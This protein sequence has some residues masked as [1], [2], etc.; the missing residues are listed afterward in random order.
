[1]AKPAWRNG[2]PGNA[3]HRASDGRPHHDPPLAVTNISDP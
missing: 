3:A 1:M 2:N